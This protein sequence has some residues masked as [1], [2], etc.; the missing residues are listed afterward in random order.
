MVVGHQGGKTWFLGPIRVRVKR[1]NNGS[2]VFKTLTLN[3]E[4]N[5]RF[6]II[7]FLSQF[8]FIIF[9]YV[10]VKNLSLLGIGSS[11]HSF[12]DNK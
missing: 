12:H 10:Q 6:K 9:L 3:G 5:Y 1:T 8:C 4:I 2:N 7:G 11:Y